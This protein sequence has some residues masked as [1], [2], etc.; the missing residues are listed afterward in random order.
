M[1]F[2]KNM[3][4]YLNNLLEIDTEYYTN[5]FEMNNND[6]W[7]IYFNRVLLQLLINVKI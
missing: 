1:K 3:L 6:D 2:T 7:K 4:D 5:D